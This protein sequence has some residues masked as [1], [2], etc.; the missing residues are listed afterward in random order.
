[1]ICKHF[2]D[3]LLNDQTLLFLIIQLSISQ[4]SLM[5]PSTFMYH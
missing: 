3:T 2:V 5:V 4:L 1:M